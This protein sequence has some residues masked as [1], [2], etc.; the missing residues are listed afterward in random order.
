M[1][2]GDFMQR[3]GIPIRLRLQIIAQK[4]SKDHLKANRWPESKVADFRNN[5]K[6][7]DY[8]DNEC[9]PNDYCSV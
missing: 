5:K 7:K 8:E 4:E 1:G 6:R 3:N 9:N 2:K